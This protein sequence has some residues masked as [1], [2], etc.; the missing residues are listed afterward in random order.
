MA[1]HGKCTFLGRSRR[2]ISS[3]ACGFILAACSPVH[4]ETA[5]GADRQIVGNPYENVK[6]EKARQHKAALHVHTLQSDGGYSVSNV[7]EAYRRAGFTILAI[8]DHDWNRPNAVSPYPKEPRPYNYPANPTWPWTD[9]GCASPEALG[10]VGIQGNELTFR[11]HINSYFSDYGVFYQRTG[12]EAPFGGIVDKE[13]KE[14]WE[15]DQLLA[16][17]DKGGLAVINHPGILDAFGWWARMPLDWYVERFRKHPA[18]YLVGIE[19]TNNGDEVT[20]KPWA[21]HAYD[22]GLWDQLLARLM[23]GR[24]IWGFGSDDM[25]A[26]TGVALSYDIFPLET[27]NAQSVRHAI[28]TGQ[29]YF[30]KKSTG[31][32]NYLTPSADIT[33]SVFPVIE[34]IRVDKQAGTIIIHARCYD[35]IRWISAPESL[36]PVADYRASQKP[37]P[38][39]TVVHVG[40]TLDYKRT[41]KIRNYVRAE[42]WRRDRRVQG[43]VYRAFTNP[44]GIATSESDRF[45]EGENK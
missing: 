8:T 33:N 45:K 11:H 31:Y 4:A 24:P 36:E 40:E 5:F 18:T 42:L 1:R 19:V 9:Y 28:K 32:V 16:V 27:A 17:R 3:L 15:D 13:G 41:P 37:W 29:F 25:H 22:E 23:P 43:V 20:G 21:S 26:L 39:G 12:P 7:V 44:F 35:E 30:V 14:V 2:L 6:W 38:L 10:M 34:R